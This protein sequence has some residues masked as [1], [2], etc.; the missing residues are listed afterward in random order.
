MPQA[1]IERFE[2]H[3]D[4]DGLRLDQFAALVCP[5]HSRSYLSSLIRGG[6]IRV[7]DAAVKPG[8]KVRDGDRVTIEI[9]AP[10][11]ISS[12]P[13]PIPLTILYEDPH[14]LVIAKPAGLV[15]H[16]GPGHFTGTLV[17]G[18]LHH[19]TDLSPIG[20]ELRPGI[21][22]RLDR[23]TSGTM[24]V[25]KSAAAHDRLSAQFKSRSVSKTYLAL[26]WGHLG[27]PSGRIDA[28]IGRHPVAR[29][30]MSTHAKRGK[31]AETLWRVRKR[32]DAGML[33]EVDLKTGRTHQIRVHMAAMG[34]PI[35]GDP[36]Y[37]RSR[38]AGGRSAAMRPAARVNRI[39]RQM[40]HAWR[41]A[42]VHP[43]T[44][45]GMCFQ[46]PLPEDMARALHWMAGEDR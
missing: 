3:E 15:V 5:D 31:P 21:V 34:H 44:G 36:V 41:L 27:R 14:L 39:D 38:A 45:E 23:D 43:I 6:S 28:P 16:P 17:N 46:S 13:E 8:R 35:I 9:P 10:Q 20:G 7:N 29:K 40:L 22:H 4:A 32:Y 42:F 1:G 12:R 33:L 18:L 11:T 2:V 25:A 19:C 37:G 26:V 30:K 24:V